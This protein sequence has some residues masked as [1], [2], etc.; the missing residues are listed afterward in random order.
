MAKRWGQILPWLVLASIAL[1]LYW[2][3]WVAP[4]EKHMGD[5]YRIAYVH[6]PSAWWALIAFTLSF[7]ASVTYLLT[8]KKEADRLAEA[9]AEVGTVFTLILLLTGSIWGKPTWNVWWTWDPRLTTAAI[10]FFAYGA[11]LALRYFVDDADKR[12]TWSAVAGILIYIDIP[13]VWKSVKLWNSLHQMQSSAD[14]V[15]HIDMRLALL[16]GV[17]AMM[18]VFLWLLRTRLRISRLERAFESALPPEVSASLPA[19]IQSGS[20]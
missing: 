12:A 6:V 19:P 7:G 17:I 3:L 16:F 18:F 14:T 10:M 11:Y 5:I 2:G 9:S 13:I 15:K 1:A 8:S 4:P 20:K